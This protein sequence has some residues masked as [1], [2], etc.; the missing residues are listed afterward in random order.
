M[1]KHRI[2][3]IKGYKSLRALNVF[4]ALL[5]GMKML[6]MYMEVPYEK[7]YDSF[8]HLSEGEKESMMREAV[9]FVRLEQEEVEAMVSFVL[10]S[11]GIPYSPVNLKNA[12]PAD[13]HE[14]I[15]AVA[16]EI[17]KIKVD[18]VSEEEKKKFQSSQSISEGHSSSTQSSH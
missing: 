9:A 7:F 13:I 8:L 18:L 2:A 11:N 15:V 17:G 14:M 5:L 3:E 10:D 16:M 1:P 12:S 6:P 4:Q